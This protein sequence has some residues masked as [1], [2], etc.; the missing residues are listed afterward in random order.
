MSILTGLVSYWKMDEASGN[1]L[2]SHGTNTLTE[3]SGTIDSAAG[4]I[5]TSRDFEAGDTEVFSIADNSSL[6][7]GD[8]DFWIGCWVKAE[9][10]AGF[11]VIAHKG[12]GPAFDV[13][14][15]WAIYVDTG[16]NCFQF[17]KRDSTNTTTLVN[18]TNFGMAT[19]GVWIRVDAWHD[20][21][22]NLIGISVNAGPPDLV[23]TSTGVNDGNREFEIGGS[24]RYGL[25]WDGLIDEAGFWKRVP[26]RGELRDLYNGGFGLEYPFGRKLN[27]TPSLSRWAVNNLKQYCRFSG[28]RW[29]V[30]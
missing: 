19:T 3:T 10:L 15:E 30:K 14:M 23:S 24:V 8:I 4:V 18:A 2:D 20:S 17:A 11:P 9:S 13:N 26:T 7:T 29:K 28:R 6:S 1:A 27:H 25:Y 16:T 12:W 5:G 22:N 21:V